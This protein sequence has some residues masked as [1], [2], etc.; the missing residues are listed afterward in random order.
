MAD[1]QPIAHIWALFAAAPAAQR[2][3]ILQGLIATCCTSQ[4]SFIA[5][6]IQPLLRID[7]TAILPP[8]ICIQIFSYLDAQSLCAACQVSRRW[9]SL[10]DDDVLWHRMCQQHIDRKCTKCGWGLPLLHKR[11]VVRLKKRPREDD[12]DDQVVSERRPEDNNNHNRKPWKR[13]YSERLVV[14]R[15]WR[16]G[17]FREVKTLQHSDAVLCL[18]FCDAQNILITGSR[19][20]TATV[21]DLETGQVLRTLRGHTRCIRTLQFDD[22]KLVTGSM[23]HTLRIWNYHTGE[24][25]RTLAGHTDGVVHLH[26]DSRILASGSADATIK[27]WNF[28][29]GQCSTLTGHTGAVTQTRIVQHEKNRLLSSSCDGTLR[30]WDLAQRVCLRV[31]QGHMASVQVAI[32]S[33]PGFLHRFNKNNEQQQEELLGTEPVVVSGSA[34]H[35]LKVWSLETGQC[36]R[37]LFGHT[38]AI[39]SLAY[40]K[41]RLVSS[42]FDGSVK[43]WDIQ[44]GDPMYTLQTGQEGHAA[45]AVAISDTKV[46]T[47][48]DHGQI[49]IW[50]FAY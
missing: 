32:P 18:Q 3:L 36:L 19:D 50:D 1:Q 35:T 46:V 23:D 13:V 22:T 11:R 7:F 25:I 14:E 41:L 26:F 27:I 21:W 45:T 6:T 10:A 33:M 37:T 44:S 4:L 20:K 2:R 29:T 12:N 30:L 40:D 17:R 15:N 5:N 49:K 34:D 28:S 39:G 24:C 9:K 31:F 47:A 48:F 43:L 8:E 16:K 42:S 38:H